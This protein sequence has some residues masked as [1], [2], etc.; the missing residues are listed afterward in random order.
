M[1]VQLT[2]LSYQISDRETTYFVHS[3]EQ[4]LIAAVNVSNDSMF[5]YEFDG[6]G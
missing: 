5:Y 4:G 6:D 1:H 2:S 3:T